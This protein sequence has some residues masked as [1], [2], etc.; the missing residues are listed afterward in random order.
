[1]AMNIIVEIAARAK[2]NVKGSTFTLSSNGRE[3]E[4]GIKLYPQ[5]TNPKY[6]GSAASGCGKVIAE[7]K[8]N[9]LFSNS[10]VKSG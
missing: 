5:P 10:G 7:R 9:K 3:E 1:M 6:D 4:E 8:Y 2:Y